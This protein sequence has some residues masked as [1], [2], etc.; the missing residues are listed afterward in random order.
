MTFSNWSYVF[1]AGICIVTENL[2]SSIALTFIYLDLIELV[3]GIV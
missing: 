1:D 2:F 3:A